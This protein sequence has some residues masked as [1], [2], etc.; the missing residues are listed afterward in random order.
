MTKAVSKDLKAMLRDVN[1]TKRFE[2]ILGENAAG[3][4]TSILQVVNGNKQL[5]EADPATI[6]NAAATAASMKLP[7]IPALGQS[8]IVPYG[9]VAQFQIGW[10][11]LVQ[12]ALRTKQYARII[13]EVVYVNQFK[14]WNAFTEHLEVDTTVKGEGEVHGFL[15]FFMTVNGFQ[16][17]VYWTKA[18]VEA[19][20]RELAERLAVELADQNP[21]FLCVMNGGLVFITQR[22][23]GF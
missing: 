17:T 23:K 5:Q 9:K 20:I 1:I 12:L 13:N 3:F 10:K 14:S 16:K 11:G 6:I 19:A 8:Y 15:A 21:L 4:V 2:E 7:I 18:E 22:N